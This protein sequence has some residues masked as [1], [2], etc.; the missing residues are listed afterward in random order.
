MNSARRPMKA[1]PLCY[2]AALLTLLPGIGC[3]KRGPETAT[4]T[5]ARRDIIGILLLNG[6]AVVPASD[7]ADILPPHR[8]T[9]AKVYTAVGDSVKEGDVLLEMSAP[10]VQSSYEQNRQ[11]VKAVETALANAER[12]YSTSIDA[13]QKRVNETRA[14]EKAARASAQ[15]ALKNENTGEN[16]GENTFAAVGEVAVSLQQAMADREAA[17]RALIQAQAARAAGLAPLKQQLAAAQAAFR[18]AQGAR[19][20]TAIRAPISGE[21]LVFNA[22]QNAEIGADARTPIITIVDLSDITFTAPVLPNQLPYVKEKTPVTLS[23]PQVPNET[24]EG[25]VEEVTTAASATGTG[26]LHSAVIDFKNDKGLVKPGMQGS[27]TIKV[28]EVKGVLAVPA[29]A[30]TMTASGQ[31]TVHVKRGEDWETAVVET[32]VSDGSYTEIKTGLKEGDVV[33]VP[34]EAGAKG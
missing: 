19:K 3:S 10:A 28:G 15:Q 32:G 11:S 12:Q 16:A 23:I 8:T 24:F 33:Q 27:A 21:I 34:G 5:V 22:S 9:V 1:L 4:A 20:E 26:Q 2:A 18:A 31:S 25:E 14:R 13:A 7:R 6:Q 29:T 30:V 17:E